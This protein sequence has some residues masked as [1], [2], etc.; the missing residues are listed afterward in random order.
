MNTFNNEKKYNKNN[1]WNTF[2][3]FKTKNK[4]A[5]TSDKF[6]CSLFLKKHGYKNKDIGLNEN[7]RILMKDGTIFRIYCIYYNDDYDGM[8]CNYDKYETTDMTRV[9][10]SKSDSL[11]KY[12]NSLLLWKKGEKYAKEHMNKAEG[13]AVH[14]Y[15]DGGKVGGLFDFPT[16]GPRD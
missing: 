7:S 11:R 12:G 2:N 15:K 9:D 8:I 1:E 13:G 14:A 5:L 16:K 10:V 3:E 6:W 4:K